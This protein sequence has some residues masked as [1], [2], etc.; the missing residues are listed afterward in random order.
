MLEFSASDLERANLSSYL[1]KPS[2]LQN[3]DHVIAWYPHGSGVGR[4]P[5]SEQQ[6]CFVFPVLAGHAIE[7]H[8]HERKPVCT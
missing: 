4:N 3:S 6:W 5:F 8:D 2:K 1:V 7:V